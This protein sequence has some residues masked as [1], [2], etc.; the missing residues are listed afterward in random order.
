LEALGV[1]VLKR[2]P[3]LTE[4]TPENYRYL[5]TKQDRMGHELGL[6]D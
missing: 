3:V 5:K 6:L 2:V 4:P 1:K